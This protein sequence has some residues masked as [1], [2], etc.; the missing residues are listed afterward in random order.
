MIQFSIFS[1]VNTI[2]IYSSY[3]RNMHAYVRW[4]LRNK[5]LFAKLI[6]KWHAIRKRWIF[7]FFDWMLKKLISPFKRWEYRNMIRKIWTIWLWY[8]LINRDNFILVFDK[9]LSR[10]LFSIYQKSCMS[11]FKIML[12]GFHWMQKNS[13]SKFV[14]IFLLRSEYTLMV[15]G[16]YLSERKVVKMICTEEHNCTN[17]NEKLSII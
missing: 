16:R 15:K 14:D 9:I 17:D 10:W 8:S 5:W 1:L 11:N 13:F 2:H 4:C 3:M 7:S 12:I 6:L